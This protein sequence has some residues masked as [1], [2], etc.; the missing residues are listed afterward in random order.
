MRMIPV[1]ADYEHHHV[2]HYPSYCSVTWI[3]CT[4]M[5]CIHTHI[6]IMS[7]DFG[8]VIMIAGTMNFMIS[9]DLP[10]LCQRILCVR[11]CIAN[12]VND[13]IRDT[14]QVILWHLMSISSLCKAN[15][16]MSIRAVAYASRS[17][18]RLL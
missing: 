6:G 1:K 8:N 3:T 4:T 10:H 17:P 14:I 11:Q 2:A 13:V 5:I 7:T 12:K 16:I 18:T 15:T 9:W